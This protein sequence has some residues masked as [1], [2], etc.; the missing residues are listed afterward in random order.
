MSK[1]LE[2]AALRDKLLLAISEVHSGNGAEGERIVD[3]VLYA[4]FPKDLAIDLMASLAAAISLLEKGGE[5][6]APSRKMFDIMLEDYKRSLDRARQ[7]FNDDNKGAK[8]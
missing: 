1:A 6:G 8:K 7:Y 5:K 3:A 2:A 4:V